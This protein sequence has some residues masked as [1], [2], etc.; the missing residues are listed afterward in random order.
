MSN[1]LDP[2]LLAVVAKELKNLGQKGDKTRKSRLNIQSPKVLKNDP[3]NQL[4]SFADKIR[5]EQKITKMRRD[6]G[7]STEESTNRIF[8]MSKEQ[9]DKQIEEYEE[10]LAAY[11]QVIDEINQQD[12]SFFKYSTYD[13]DQR[14][15]EKQE[16]LILIKNEYPFLTEED[17]YT[18]FKIGNSKESSN[19]ENRR[20]FESVHKIVK[21]GVPHE[22]PDP[23]V[24]PLKM[25][26]QFLSKIQS[27]S[28]TLQQPVFTLRTT[29]QM[30]DDISKRYM[31]ERDGYGRIIN[32]DDEKN[33]VSTESTPDGKDVM[34]QMM[35]EPDPVIGNIRIK[36]AYPNI[37]DL[38]RSQLRN[39]YFSIPIISKQ[40]DER[41]GK[42]ISGHIDVQI[43][44]KLSEAVERYELMLEGKAPQIDD[45]ADL[46]I[47]FAVS[48]VYDKDEIIQ[49]SDYITSTIQE[50]L[51]TH[52]IIYNVDEIK[53]LNQQAAAGRHSALL[54]LYR[55]EVY[56]IG[57]SSMGGQVEVNEGGLLNMFNKMIGATKGLIATRDYYIDINTDYINLQISDVGVLRR[58]HLE[59][60]INYSR[61]Y[62]NRGGFGYVSIGGLV[63]DS[64]NNKYNLI[65]SIATV[66]HY[67]SVSDEDKE[68][69][70]NL[71]AQNKQVKEY[72]ENGY[73]TNY[74]TQF[75]L[76]Y[77]AY[78]F[79][80]SESSILSD[81]VNIF[82][83]EYANMLSHYGTNCARFVQ[84]ILNDRITCG[85]EAFGI[86]TSLAVPSQCKRL[87]H[88]TQ[89]DGNYLIKFFDLYMSNNVSGLIEHFQS[90][91]IPKKS[92]FRFGGKKKTIKKKSKPTIK[93]KHH[94]S[95]KTHRKSRK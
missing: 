18:I 6:I 49:M 88:L 12:P 71:I 55:R 41:T 9:G 42:T 13:N 84:S 35:S 72:Y 21:S 44:P 93:R 56:S 68:E 48:S 57:Y 25:V 54:I 83:H 37:N 34:F 14:E 66:N 45:V 30:N 85:L 26:A 64:P 4:Q 52:G 82:S 40:I 32:V 86:G 19:E 80:T 65:N 11:E 95:R 58:N 77:D 46:P 20:L 70:I 50:Q 87:G 59:N 78:I 16:K 7:M 24:E 75:F 81:F 33:L 36:D 74:G 23:Y 90:G 63:E 10:K 89:V 43:N 8:K 15:M 61:G 94:K 67:N 2:R 29:E 5:R 76:P 92:I 17:V 1:E 62:G 39:E 69:I 60:L 53:K 31:Y 51:A 28:P 38:I 79:Q 91:N 73:L 22:D 3:K 27:T 47:Y